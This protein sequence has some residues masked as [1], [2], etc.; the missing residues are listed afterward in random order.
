MFLKKGKREGAVL[1]TFS[2]SLLFP[3]R[4]WTQHALVTMSFSGPK[5]LSDPVSTHF[6]GVEMGSLKPAAW[7]SQWGG[8]VWKMKRRS[9]LVSLAV[10]SLCLSCSSWTSDSHAAWHCREGRLHTSLKL[11][12]C[13]PTSRGRTLFLYL[14]EVGDVAV[15]QP[16]QQLSEVAPLVALPAFP[17]GLQVGVE[18]FSPVLAALHLQGDL[19]SHNTG[20]KGWFE[21]RERRTSTA[22]PTSQWDNVALEGRDVGGLLAN[23]RH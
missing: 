8:G 12:Y 14:L 6:P 17:V 20:D 23:A 10:S 4:P 2:L 7:R 21:D 19:K 3:C 9:Q 13:T 1:Y 11:S 5:D 15:G 22:P 16:G 18:A